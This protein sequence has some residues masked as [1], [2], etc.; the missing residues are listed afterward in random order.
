[1]QLIFNQT[2]RLMLRR[3][4]VPLNQPTRDGELQIAILSNLPVGK[5][6]TLQI[7]ALYQ[8]RWRIARLFQVLEPCFRG[9]IN[10]LA[11]PKAALLGFGI[12]LIGYNL[13]TVAKAAM[14]SVHRADKI[15]AGISPDYLADEVRWVYEHKYLTWCTPIKKL[16]H[17]TIPVR[18]RSSAIC[19][20]KL[21]LMPD[22]VI[23]LMLHGDK[24]G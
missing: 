12:A 2:L 7:A 10:A 18:L 17:K 5:A 19:L 6:D 20:A 16:A 14:R 11:Y 3:I 15:E 4:G 22:G 23:E 13:L 21:M 8:K 1:V 9:E 24:V